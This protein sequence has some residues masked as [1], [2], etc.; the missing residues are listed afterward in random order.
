MWS[1]KYIIKSES[2]V[3]ILVYWENYNNHLSFIIFYYT[4]LDKSYLFLFISHYKS[5][6]NI[7]I[8]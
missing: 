8:L 2:S 6:V 1:V 4:T 7:I 5:I 3:G